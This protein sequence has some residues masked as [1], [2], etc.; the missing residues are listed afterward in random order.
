MKIFFS[1]LLIILL[2]PIGAKAVCDCLSN[3]FDLMDTDNDGLNDSQELYFYYTSRES[4]DSDGDG[5]DDRT[6]LINGYSP[7]FTN[8]ARLI[9]YDQDRDGLNDGY[10]LA[11]K[12][13]LRNSDSDEDGHS[14]G[15]EFT[16]GYDPANKEAVKLEKRIEVNLT[17]QRLRYFLGPVKIN[18]FTVSSGKAVTP[19]PS[20]EFTIEKKSERAWSEMAG[21]WM[22]WWMS[23][24]GVYAIHELPEWPDGTKEGTNHLGVPVSHGCIRLGIGPAK[25]LYDW[26]PIG[27]KLIVSR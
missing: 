20:G 2:F 13:D 24:N 11:L 17:A 27:T 15:L 22:P 5:Y 23:F 19:T 4:A 21:L 26:T 8:K 16:N 3:D 10:E 14:D 25:L 9:D 12:T 1:I 18:E 6:E 7:H